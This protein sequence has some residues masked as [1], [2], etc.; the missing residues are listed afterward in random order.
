MSHSNE[1]E[2]QLLR[3]HF[4]SLLSEEAPRLDHPINDLF[5]QLDCAAGELRLYDDTDEELSRLPV[6]AWEDTGSVDAPSEA[7][8]ETLRE[9]V[10][11]LEQKGY[12]DKTLFARPFSVV[13]VRSDFS[14][15]EEL[16]F[17]DEELVQLSTP[18][19][20]GLNDELNEFLSELLVDLK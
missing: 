10:T 11:R 14:V 13:L 9:V 6:Y 16:L 20:E 18:L 4:L 7:A 8:L 17:L 2:L 15:L 19:L 12:W 3:K 5:I 1:R